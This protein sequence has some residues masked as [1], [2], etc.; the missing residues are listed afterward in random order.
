VAAAPTAEPP[1]NRLRPNAI[2]VSVLVLL[3]ALLAPVVVFWRDIQPIVRT[4]LNSNGSG[5]G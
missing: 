4:I 5:G 3:I 2:A 1:K